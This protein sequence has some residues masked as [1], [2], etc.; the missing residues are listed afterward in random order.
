MQIRSATTSIADVEADALVVT[1]FQVGEGEEP[2]AQVSELT[3][4]LYARGEFSGK[5]LETAVIHRPE[6]LKVSRLLLVGGGKRDEF[7]LHGARDVAAVAVRKLQTAG[8]KSVALAI[9][10]GFD[11]GALAQAATEGALLASFDVGEMKTSEEGKGALEEFVVIAGTG[12]GNFV[13]RGRVI[14]EGQNFARS[15]GNAPANILTPMELVERA[16]VMAAETGLGFEV[17]DRDAMAEMGMGALLGVA[18]GSAEPPAM[19]ILRYTP[20]VA[21]TKGEHLGLV[22]KAVTFDTGGVSIKPSAGMDLMKYDMCGGAAVLGAMQAIAALKPLKPVTALVPTVENMVGS[23]AQRPGDV[24]TTLSGKT[25]EIL[26]TDAEGR[27]ILADALTYAQ[28]I[29]CTELVDAAT[30]TGAIVVALGHERAGLFAND[31]ALQARVLAAA[32]ATGEKFWPMPLDEE[33]KEQLKSPIADL[34]NIGSRW[35]G[36]ITA[37]MFLK[38]FADPLP[39]VHLDIAGTAW[40]EADKPAMPKGPTGMAVRTF[41][42]L[43]M[44][45]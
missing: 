39:W 34:P 27:M 15:L 28:Q 45:A 33:Y 23:R 25:V 21:P 20:E 41:V 2:D 5:K 16:R 14:G 40:L 19:I 30:L 22:G 11:D 13:E 17:L 6:G 18:Q 37:A 10:T 38:Q 1:L 26:N 4:E 36:S 3:A 43:A 9:P 8:A 7:T 32:E 31:L 24:V 12:V 44:K 42:E 35:G 29:G